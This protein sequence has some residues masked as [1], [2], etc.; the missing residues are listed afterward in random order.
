MQFDETALLGQN[1]ALPPPIIRSA[2][3]AA[4]ELF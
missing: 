2:A 4:A 3:M 1:I